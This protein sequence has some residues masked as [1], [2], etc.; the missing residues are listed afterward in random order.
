MQLQ[1]AQLI[2]E[3]AAECGYE[4]TARPSYSG[5]GMYGQATA[6]VVGSQQEIVASVAVAA[7]R[8]GQGDNADA[9]DGDNFLEDVARLRWDN[10]GRDAIAY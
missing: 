2:A 4:V 5:R 3:A 1:T 7:Y 10:M 8:L 6:G 9:S